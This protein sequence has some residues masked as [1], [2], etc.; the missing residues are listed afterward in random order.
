[1]QL[2]TNFSPRL[3]VRGKHAFPQGIEC[4]SCKTQ[5][6]SSLNQ[7]QTPPPL[8]G[9]SHTLSGKSSGFANTSFQFFLQVLQRSPWPLLEKHGS[10]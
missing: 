9:K 1:M 8:L 3:Q 5:G 6:N 4:D 10:I 2:R 7:L